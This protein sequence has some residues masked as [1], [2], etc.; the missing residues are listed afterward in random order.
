MCEL[1]E[2]YRVV[3]RADLFVGREAEQ[4]RLIAWAS[5]GPPARLVVVEGEAGSAKTPGRG[6]ASSTARAATVRDD[7]PQAGLRTTALDVDHPQFRLYRF[8]P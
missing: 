8:E 1:G 6:Q 3:G 5:A 7:A 2:T 4:G